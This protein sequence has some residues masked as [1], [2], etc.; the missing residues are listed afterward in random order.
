MLADF[1][2]FVAFL[3]GGLAFRDEIGHA[4]TH[5]RERGERALMFFRGWLAKDL[6]VRLRRYLR[7][8]AFIIAICGG[9]AYGWH[10]YQSLPFDWTYSVANYSVIGSVALLLVIW[11]LSCL[12]KAVPWRQVF[13]SL[14]YWESMDA[15]QV[16]NAG[17]APL[18]RP[19][20]PAS[21]NDLLTPPEIED[22]FKSGRF[23]AVRY[24]LLMIF[25]AGWNAVWFIIVAGR[26]YSNYDVDW[27][28]QAPLQLIAW[29][30]GLTAITVWIL[31]AL[32]FG[33]S[34]SE[35][36]DVFNR[37][38]NTILKPLLVALPGIT[39]ENYD[40]VMPKPLELPFKSV[41]EFVRLIHR[42]PLYLIAFY[43]A[44]TLG[45]PYLWLDMGLLVLLLF[46]ISTDYVLS[47]GGEIETKPTTQAFMKAFRVVGGAILGWRIVQVIVWWTYHR[48]RLTPL[49]VY[50]NDGIE[51]YNHFTGLAGWWV[52]IF[53]AIVFAIALSLVV[54]AI[55]K[56]GAVV[57]KVR[58]GLAATFAILLG[59][60]VLGRV[61]NVSGHPMHLDRI[62]IAAH[63]D[64]ERGN[65]NGSVAPCPAGQ[66]HC[67]A[68]CVDTRSD[69]LHCGGC[70]AV[71]Y[72]GA[73][74]ASV[75]V[76]PAAPPAPA[77][78]PASG[79]AHSRRS[80]TPMVF[81]PV[82]P[83][84]PARPCSEVGDISTSRFVQAYAR[85]G[86][87]DPSR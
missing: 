86:R 46:G 36:G 12:C 35:G 70:G 77:V 78:P 26:L 14:E 84:A 61:A 2:G 51:W 32:V 23:T 60:V 24:F 25:L 17:I 72:P 20:A 87:C 63:D 29:I 53:A 76:T 49:T 74:R 57:G 50:L 58:I 80:R 66:V 41:G 67:G 43:A 39:E 68:Q 38:L 82:Q 45:L 47:K 55:P 52:S 15:Y 9:A 30:L 8:T 22:M 1:M 4:F 81:T 59:L 19:P 75:C 13:R 54:K 44:F 40:K 69:N 64:P 83:A 42:S 85:R 79:H 6:A 34:L 3:V 28:L 27:H 48:A 10:R 65:G 37:I 5:V 7:H 16:T 62:P 33:K 73:C 18:L 21:P 56:E 11:L 31:A 71:C